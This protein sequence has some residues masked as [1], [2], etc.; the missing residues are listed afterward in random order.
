MAREHISSS[1]TVRRF[2]LGTCAAVVVTGGVRATADDERVPPEDVLSIASDEPLTV[3][4]ATSVPRARVGSQ[5]FR[6]VRESDGEPARGRYVA[7][8]F[9]T[10]HDTGNPIVLDPEAWIQAV[11]VVRALDR[12][13]ATRFVER[14][15]DRYAQS[16]RR[17]DIDVLWS[18]IGEIDAGSSG[19]SGWHYSPEL[20][21]AEPTL[22]QVGRRRTLPQQ[23]ASAPEE[24]RAL[25]KLQA[26][27]D[28][29]WESYVTESDLAAFQELA[30]D[31]TALRFH[32]SIDPLTGEP[33]VDSDFRRLES[34]RYLFAN[35][36]PGRVFTFVPDVPQSAE[37]VDAAFAPNERYEVRFAG[38]PATVGGLLTA[39]GFRAA[40][41]RRV[42]H[43]ETTFPDHQYPQ[44]YG[45]PVQQ[46]EFRLSELKSAALQVIDVTPPSGEL[47]VDPWTDWESP[48]NRFLVIQPERRP[49]VVRVR[50][51]QPLRPS[52]VT[53]STFVLTQRRASIGTDNERSVQ[54]GVPVNV[55]L[56]QSRL[57]DVEVEVVPRVS[58]DPAAQ[59]ELTVR[60]V[61]TALNGRQPV[62]DALSYFTTAPISSQT[63]VLYDWF[64][65]PAHF[66][67][68]ADNQTPRALVAAD[69]AHDPDGL[70]LFVPFLGDDPVPVRAIETG[71][72]DGRGIAPRYEMRFDDPATPQ[73]EG[74]TVHAPAGSSV[75]VFARTTPANAATN[76]PDAFHV[77]PWIEL[78]PAHGEFLGQ[79]YVQLRIEFTLPPGATPSTPDLPYVDRVSLIARRP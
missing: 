68:E 32:H 10:D 11:Q 60:S 20:M 58:L 35:A 33:Y 40:I 44:S 22:L 7:G 67:A 64:T 62:A 59:Y 36:K 2:L 39:S 61:V 16:G 3:R 37:A 23:D 15:L 4:F 26:G 47:L 53:P 42:A 9:A 46:P 71:W 25:R 52:S 24:L 73:I 1:R 45:T 17:R 79:H 78:D 65:D 43:V 56:R 66:W 70:G 38:L 48:D 13:A 31:P 6:I 49:F 30:A 69:A 57:G 50:F 18:A 5:S 21:G 51:N 8:T 63:D 41:T 19:S 34:R 55:S 12:E 29:L 54:I 74:T 28:A 76:S 14:A 27:D 75:R 77:G 72:L